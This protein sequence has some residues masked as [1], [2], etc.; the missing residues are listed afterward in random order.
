MIESPEER[1]EFLDGRRFPAR[2]VMHAAM[3]N[4]NAITNYHQKYGLD[5]ALCSETAG[6]GRAR[7]YCLVDVYQ[8]ALI[9]ALTELTGNVKWAV[10]S[11]EGLLFEDHEARAVEAAETQEID[12]EAEERFYKQLVCKSIDAAPL[13]YKWRDVRRPVLLYATPPDIHFFNP[14]RYAKWGDDSMDYTFQGGIVWNATMHLI[15]V[16][17]LLLEFVN[18]EPK[19]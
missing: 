19:T 16:D 7:Q 4:Q 2:A 11:L 8:V 14:I 6:Q 13:P 3:V 18:E 17:N 1:L 10:M 9:Q 15:G 5:S 12:G